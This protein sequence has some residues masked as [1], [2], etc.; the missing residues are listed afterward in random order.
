[1]IR[2]LEERV[3]R[4]DGERDRVIGQ[5]DQR[6]IALPVWLGARHDGGVSETPSFPLSR[7]LGMTVHD[8]GAGQARADLDAGPV[9]HNPTVSCM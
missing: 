5:P 6:T 2:E 8:D 1:M 4:T 3:D 9:H 7:F